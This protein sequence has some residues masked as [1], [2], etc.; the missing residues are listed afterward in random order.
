LESKRLDLVKEK[1]I[2]QTIGKVVYYAA[3]L[4]IWWQVPQYVLIG[5][6]EIFASI[7]GLEFAYSAAPKSMQSAI[8]GLFF[9]F[10]GVGSFVGSGLLE[11]VS[12]KAIGWMS[13]HTDFGNIN[14]CHLNYYFFL[15]AAI[16]GATLLLFLIVSVRY[17]RQRSRASGAPAGRR[18]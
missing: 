12:I 14:G 13:N 5:I 7:A 2:N 6:S 8:M 17:D 9:F 10:S 18:T 11:L 15:L 3:D 4:P 1:T 16:Q